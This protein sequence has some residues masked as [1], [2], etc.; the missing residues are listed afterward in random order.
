MG[1]KHGMFQYADRTD[2]LLM[3]LGTLGSIGDGL[4]VPLMMFVLSKVI[5]DYGKHNTSGSIIPFRVM[6]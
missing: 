2:K 3:T 5:N 1:K 4:Q 6:L